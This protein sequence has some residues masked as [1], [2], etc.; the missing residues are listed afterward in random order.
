[1]L[2]CWF[3]VTLGLL[4]ITSIYFSFFKARSLLGKKRVESHK[5][6]TALENAI[7]VY[8]DI[9]KETKGLEKQLQVGS[10]HVEIISDND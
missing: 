2:S 7:E 8:K 10:R 1:M 5:M 9:L 6:K 3:T 4:S